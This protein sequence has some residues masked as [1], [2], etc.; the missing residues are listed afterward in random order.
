MITNTKKEYG[1]YFWLHVVALLIAYLSP[2]IINWKIIVVGVAILQVQ[3]IV[4][5]GCYLTHLEFGKDKKEVFLWYYLRRF[6]PSLKPNTTKFFVRVVAPS[7][8]IVAGYI[9]QEFW[10]FRPLLDFLK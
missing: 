6:F 9:I 4:I 7:L 2:I 1:L 3:Y 8:V 10:N 5:N